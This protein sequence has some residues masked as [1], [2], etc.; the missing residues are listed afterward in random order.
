MARHHMFGDDV[1]ADVRSASDNWFS[2]GWLAPTVAFANAVV[3]VAVVRYLNPSTLPFLTDAIDRVTL[4][5]RLALAISLI[6]NITRLWYSP[7]WFVGVADLVATL[8]G[9]VATVRLFQVYPFAFDN[10]TIPWTS[11]VRLL[12]VAA[13][14]GAASGIALATSRLLAI[15]RGAG[16]K[17]AGGSDPNDAR[18]GP[19]D[20]WP[21]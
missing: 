21:R 11:V 13:M 8:A 7:S 16:G 6:G 15:R 5:I 3:L 12:L 19:K 20:P 4:F 10:G 14:V 1:L 9:L 2:F 18:E 17:A